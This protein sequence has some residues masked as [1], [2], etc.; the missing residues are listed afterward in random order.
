MRF[1]AA[2]HRDGEDFFNGKAVGRQVDLSF[3]AASNA[4][5]IHLLLVRPKQKPPPRGFPVFVGMNACG[6]FATV[7]N[8]DVPLPTG[9]IPKGCPDC[10]DLH[11]TEAGRG[12]QV[13]VWSMEECVGRGY[14]V[15]TFYCGDIEPDQTNATTGNRHLQTQSLN[16]VNNHLKFLL[17]ALARI[18]NVNLR[19]GNHYYFIIPIASSKFTRS[20][21][22]KK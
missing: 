15:A 9:L 1:Q 5:T 17:V 3:G 7:T 21:M 6:N 10:V 20:A 16:A 4:P 22:P 11:A 2:I 19:N 13:G 12:K 8:T 14:A 18:Q